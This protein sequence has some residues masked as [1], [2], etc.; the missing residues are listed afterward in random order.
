[1][2]AKTGRPRLLRGAKALPLLPV[3]LPDNDIY[4]AD[5]QELLDRCPD[6]LPIEEIGAAWGPLVSLGREVA[7]AAGPVDNL[8]V[9]PTGEITVVEAK[10]WRNP[11]ARRKVV[12]Q[13][14]DY[15]A[16]LREMS[17]EEL[18]DRVREGVSK[19]SIWDI[20]QASEWAPPPQTEA[21]FVDRVR[22]NLRTGRF[23]LLVVGDGIHSGLRSLA[24]LLSRHPTLGF[25]LE[26]VELRLFDTPDGDR[27]VVPSLVGRS[28][29]VVRAIISIT[30]PDDVLVSVVAETPAEPGAPRQ[31]LSSLEDFVMRASDKIEPARAEAMADLAR[32]WRRELGGT[33]RFGASSVA[34]WAQSPH[35]GAASVMSM[36]LDGLAQGS[37][38][39]LARTRGFVDPEVA[40]D[41]YT[42]AGFDGDADWPSMNLDP[43]IE[44]E[45]LRIEELLRWAA[46]MVREGHP[47]VSDQ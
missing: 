40:F 39:S 17:Y 19:R 5:L 24:D 47:K 42:A 46:Q 22:V 23:L 21:D 31:K 13:V 2:R 44:S 14:L 26:L 36:Y 18:D 30:K 35:G 27:I 15:A 43:T 6:L 1:M 7:T 4:E 9:S 11:E 10:L 8:Y 37:I 12:G 38:G 32:W 29:E 28:E 41:R 20:V 3:P 34:L 25:H 33:L 45:R 16:A